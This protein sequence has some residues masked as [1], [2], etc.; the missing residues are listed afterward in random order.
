[1]TLGNGVGTQNTLTPS[2]EAWDELDPPIEPRVVAGPSC[3]LK[4][5]GAF[6]MILLVTTV[7][8]LGTRNM[9]RVKSRFIGYLTPRSLHQIGHRPH[10]TAYLSRKLCLMS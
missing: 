8:D 9:M 10:S 4:V 7:L 6:S 3:E 5:D 2:V 1:V